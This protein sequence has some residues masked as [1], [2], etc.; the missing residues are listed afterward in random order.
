MNY[1]QTEALIFAV[2]AHQH[3]TRKNGKPYVVHPIRVMYNLRQ[4]LP[5]NVRAGAP[6]AE[7]ALLHDVV[8]DTDAIEAQLREKFGDYIAGAV[9]EVT[10]DQTLSKGERK[11]AQLRSAPH[12]SRVARWVKMADML[13]NLSDRLN[14]PDTFSAEANAAYFGWKYA[15]FRAFA[16]GADEKYLA[17]ALS[18]IFEVAK[19][20]GVWTE[21]DAEPAAL[22]RYF[23]AE[24]A[25]V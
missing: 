16:L 15:I 18:S 5:E 4:F 19:E 6:W 13:D 24:D 12:K 20:R 11:R 8:E 17:D 14:H 9:M 3:Q 22:E 1:S 25:K 7:V 10:D 2:E 23:A 21:A